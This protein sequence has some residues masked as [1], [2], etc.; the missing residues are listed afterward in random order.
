MSAKDDTATRIADL[1]GIKY[2]HALRLIRTVNANSNAEYLFSDLAHA[3]R[4]LKE[5]EEQDRETKPNGASKRRR[6]GGV[7][8]KGAGRVNC[9]SS[10]KCDA[11]AAADGKGSPIVLIH[12]DGC[13]EKYPIKDHLY[14]AGHPRYDSEGCIALLEGCDCVRHKTRMT[15]WGLYCDTEQQ[16]YC[17]FECPHIC[18]LPLSKHAHSEYPED[19]R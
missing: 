17:N 9:A 18:G 6:S 4:E 19:G 11:T 10:D 7:L 5:S 15:A 3:C 13:P 1:L 14:D 12:D 16:G 8:P 2:A